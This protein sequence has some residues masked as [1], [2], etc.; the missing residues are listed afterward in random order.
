MR[1]EV[2][3]NGTIAPTPDLARLVHRYVVSPKLSHSGISKAARL[4]HATL[5]DFAD[6][7]AVLKFVVGDARDVAEAAAI[8]E[9]AA[10]T[11]DRVWIMPLGT[12][13]DGTLG[14]ARHLSETI[15]RSGFNLSLRQHLLLWG[16][17]R[18]R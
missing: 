13:P 16:D 4:R 18:G 7:E 14:L 17:Q 15:L 12:D 2:E 1:C 8:A 9:A 3:T 5:R 10:F 6:C 11:A